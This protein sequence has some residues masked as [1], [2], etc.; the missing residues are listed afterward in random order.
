MA[1]PLVTIVV[2][3]YNG[4]TYLPGFLHALSE[5]TFKDFAV[6]FVYDKSDDNTLALLKEPHV[7][8]SQVLEKPVKESVGKARDYALD[9]GLIL[10]EY[11][12][13]V[14]ADDNPHVDY[15]EKL[16][17]KAEETSADIALCGF[18]RVNFETKLIISEDMC[19]NP[20]IIDD[21]A[22]SPVV[23]FFNP[24][25]WNKLIRT[26]IV[27]DAR[28]VH[29]AG[30]GED[31]MFFLKV[32]PNAGKLAFVNEAL[33]DYYVHEG[34][35]ATSTSRANYDEACKGYLEVKQYY[36]DHQGIYLPFLPLL[37]AKVFLRIA[38]GT[39]TR[40]SIS[41]PEL[42]HQLIKDSK[43]YMDLNFS[44]WTKNRYLSHKQC[45]ALGKKAMYVWHCKRLYQWHLFGLFIWAYKT[46]TRIRHKDVKW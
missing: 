11:L 44:G 23:P 13:F 33:Y 1:I 14:D 2:P 6:V 28:F 31:E 35:A 25:P 26:S 21:P 45:H 5:Q 17:K 7:F 38:L 27:G 32:L 42:K 18:H 3:A 36:I 39:T 46:Y 9:S 10:S 16:V 30:S 29:K 34:S 41:N 19:H 22:R 20:D 4:A 43:R 40:L 15:L 8:P 12:L 24:A 37:E